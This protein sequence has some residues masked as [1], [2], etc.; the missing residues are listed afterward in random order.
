[1]VEWARLWYCTEF[2]LAFAVSALAPRLWNYILANNTIVI[3]LEPA[4]V[5]DYPALRVRV[6][7]AADKF[8]FY[9]LTL[10]P[11]IVLIRRL[12]RILGHR[13]DR[14][15]LDVCGLAVAVSVAVAMSV[16]QTLQRLALR[17]P[18]DR[19]VERDQVSPCGSCREVRPAAGI[20]IDAQ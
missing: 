14:R 19:R 3:A 8:Q 11:L 16:A 15:P 20:E 6:G 9:P 12:R 7:P 17:D 13:H 4:H 2:P 5:P 1:M 10:D 18:M